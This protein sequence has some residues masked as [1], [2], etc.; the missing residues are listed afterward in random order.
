MQEGPA[1]GRVHRYSHDKVIAIEVP[2]L[3]TAETEQLA[4]PESANS[5]NREHAIVSALDKETD[6]C[7]IDVWLPRSAARQR[8]TARAH[9]IDTMGT[10]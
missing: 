2:L 9:G 8:R 6:K 3:P 7:G 10:D 5:E 1:K 4:M